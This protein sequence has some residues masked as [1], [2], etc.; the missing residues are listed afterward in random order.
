MPFQLSGINIHRLRE[1]LSDDDVVYKILYN[2]MSLLELISIH[3]AT[4]RW[5][6]SKDLDYWR[7]VAEAGDWEAYYITYYNQG[8]LKLYEHICSLYQQSQGGASVTYSKEGKV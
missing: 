7:R 5:S 6:I 3:I 1:I 2:C 4:E 8:P